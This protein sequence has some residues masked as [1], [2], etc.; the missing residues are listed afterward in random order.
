MQHPS[1]RGHFRGPVQ[2]K[3]CLMRDWEQTLRTAFEQILAGRQCTEK[4][5]FVLTDGKRTVTSRESS[6]LAMVAQFYRSHQKRAGS[7]KVMV[8]FIYREE[9][10]GPTRSVT[11]LLLVHSPPLLLLSSTNY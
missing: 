8:I 5:I 9:N 6:I 2:G 1:L 10:E 7:E 4:H 3:T 11:E